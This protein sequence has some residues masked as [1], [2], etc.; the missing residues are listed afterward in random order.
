MKKKGSVSE[1]D[2]RHHGRSL[3]DATGER[4]EGEYKNVK[5]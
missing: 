2:G 5:L 4:E 3:L 1:Q